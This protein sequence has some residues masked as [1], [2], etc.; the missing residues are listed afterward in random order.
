MDRMRRGD[1]IVTMTPPV[2]MRFGNW[3]YLW[4]H[5]HAETAAG[6]PWLVLE[7][8][9]MKPWLTAFPALRSLTVRTDELRFHD[10]RIWNDRQRN[11]RFGED[12]TRP[13][14]DAFVR[15]MLAP[16]LLAA[17]GDDVVVNVRRG[18]YYAQPHLRAIYSFDQVGYLTEALRRIAP[19]TGIRVV[20][21]DPQ[22]C[23][24]N[25]GTMLSTFADEVTYDA[26]DPLAN[27]IAVSTTRRLIGT[28]STFS[29]WGG[30]IAGVLHAHPQIVMPR[31][32]GR[33][34]SGSDAFQLDPTW[35][36]IDGHA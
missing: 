17:P 6:R 10:A 34:D 5:A 33:S 22:W 27:F 14:L 30:Y 29:Y 7:A 15:D 26:Q 20:S 9:G 11:Q 28:N 12:F 13:Q 35:T 16:E 31:F 2:G 36:I 32:H 24:E 21:D 18:D 3:L 1:R 8:P 25:L 19:V 23:A 4:M